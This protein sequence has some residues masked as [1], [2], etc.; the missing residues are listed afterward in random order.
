VPESKKLPD[1]FPAWAVT[2]TLE[3]MTQALREPTA[4]AELFKLA[5]DP[6]FQSAVATLSDADK[7]TL[8]GVFA[9]RRDA[10]DV[11]VKLDTFDGM[12]INLV[13]IDWWHSDRYV[14]ESKGQTG[15]GVT[16]HVRQDDGKIVKALTSSS[17]VVRFCNRLRE[18]PSENKP[19]RVFLE[20]VPVR[21]PTRAAR[22]QMMWSIKAMPPARASNNTDGAPF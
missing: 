15:D 3:A 6:E 10:L 19:M 22:G 1:A 14:D 9:E 17:P 20:L 11:K 7:K 13:G 5:N 12:V 16:L 2:P 8:R 4:F 18:L 21:D